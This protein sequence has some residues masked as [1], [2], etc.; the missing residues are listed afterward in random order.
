MTPVAVRVGRQRRRVAEH[1]VHLERA[2][3]ILE[4]PARLGIERRQRCEARRQDAHRIRV[5]W[6][7][8][9]QLFDP[10]RRRALRFDGLREAREL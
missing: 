3:P 10:L 9:E 1:A 5:V 6:K 8:A 2:I 7:S 4:D